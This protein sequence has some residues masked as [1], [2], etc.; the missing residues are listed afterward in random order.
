MDRGNQPTIAEY[1]IKVVS[2][3]L[4]AQLYRQHQRPDLA[5]RMVRA[6][7]DSTGEWVLEVEQ[8]TSC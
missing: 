6:A 8:V 7:D 1:W 2:H 4:H 5:S 3:S